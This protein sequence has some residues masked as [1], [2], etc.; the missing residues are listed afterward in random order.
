MA[1]A[2]AVWLVLAHCGA[3]AQVN[4]SSPE[5]DVASIKATPPLMVKH[6]CSGGPGTSGP[7]LLTCENLTLFNF[8]AMAYRIQRYEVFGPDWIHAESFDLKAKVPPGT[9]MAQC[10][11]MVQTMLKERFRLTLHH[12]DRTVPVYELAVLK[13]G[14]KL[15]GPSSD[16]GNEK[17]PFSP[18][19]PQP[20]GGLRMHMTNQP[21]AMFVELIAMHLDRPVADATGLKGK[22]DFDLAWSPRRTMAASAPSDDSGPDLMLAVQ[23]Q[24]GLKLVQTNG[25]HNV[26]VIDHVDKVPTE[27]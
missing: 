17:G 21:M 16:S 4:G 10:R 8:L 5:F 12:E 13:A 24:L 19:R 3:F 26:L 11:L 6:G 9:D 20:G 18:V 25:P 27:N 14:H 15:K 23:E 7:G 1:T 22:Y 2:S